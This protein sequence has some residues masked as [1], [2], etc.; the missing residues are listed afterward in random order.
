ME[1][2]K[3]ELINR[4]IDEYATTWS[5]TLDTGDFIDAKFLKKIDKYIY[6]N[7]KKKFK[8][9]EI[10]NLL[11]LQEQGYK[12]GLFQKLKI[13]FS[14]LKPLYVSEQEHINLQEEIMRLREELEKARKPKR[15]K[16]SEIVKEIA[17][18]EQSERINSESGLC[19]ALDNGTSE[20]NSCDTNTKQ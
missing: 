15:K 2:K 7:L 4:T 18:S 3:N 16:R 9:I 11:Y 13:S 1:F 14:G 10:Y 19:S 6:N 20:L 17:E 8:E 12:L 5:H